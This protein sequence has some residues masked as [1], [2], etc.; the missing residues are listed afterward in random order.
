VT[1][2]RRWQSAPYL[3][4]RSKLV[5][6]LEF[7][8]ANE[9]RF[10]DKVGKF[11]RQSQAGAQYPVD[12]QFELLMNELTQEGA[13]EQARQHGV[14]ARGPADGLDAFM[15]QLE[16]FI[17]QAEEDEKER[18]HITSFDFP[19]K[20]VSQLVGRQGGNINALREKYD[21]EID[22]Q[23]DKGKVHI[24]GPKKNATACQA[25]IM[26]A[27]KGWEDEVNFSLIMEPRF[28][29][30]VIGKGGENLTKLQNKYD[31][32]RIQFPRSGSTPDDQS[33]AD[34]ASQIGG[35]RKSRPAQA[36]NVVTVRGPRARA[37]AVRKELLDLEQF[38][39]DHSQTTSVSVA[40]SQIPSL[41]GKGGREM[42]LLRADTGANIDVPQM[43]NGGSDR[44]EIKLTGS[45]EQINAAKS[46][47]LKKSKTFD[48]IVERRLI[49][50]KKHHKDLIG[51]GGANIRKIV[52]AAGG[53]EN[54]ARAVQFPKGDGPD[55]N[56]VVVRGP[57]EVVDKIC[58]ALEAL[59]TTKDNEITEVVDVPAERHFQLIGTGGDIRKRLETEFGVSINVPRRGSGETGVKITGPASEVSKAISH[60][61]NVTKPKPEARVDIPKSLHHTVS[62]N[63]RLF[64]NLRNQGIIVVHD[65]VRAPP[66]P[67][68]GASTPRTNGNA[69]L[70]TDDPADSFSW[71]MITT[72]P[73]AGDEDM[74][75]WIL[76]GQSEENVAAARKKVEEALEKASKPSTT[77]YLILS[78]PKLHR[79]V[80]GKG[81]SKVGEIRDKTG[82]I[83]QIPQNKP[84]N[85]SEAITIIGD[86]EA[87]EE[88]KE[89]I[90]EAVEEGQNRS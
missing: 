34:D 10:H 2:F 20:Y 6:T 36:A 83:I 86:R 71:S 63:G 60:I 74:I 47:L 11:G 78:D 48:D 79:H 24:K 1:A 31:G 23:K 42:E 29:R 67:E 44:V 70:I 14:R 85:A 13:A 16:A 12:L 65:G 82:C 30:M 61:S 4:P 27:L 28:H 35:S 18:G 59:A 43:D 90:L 19:E 77:G 56:E 38:Y 49:I 22:T 75:P 58:A 69:P 8:R 55:S 62:N 68:S 39:K 3:F 53:P 37:E 66:K 87:C 64:A 21:V 76:R 73:L 54:N 80:V 9:H 32:V 72:G 52:T 40:R 15:K 17:K 5:V 81:G 7:I 41:M 51:A 89:M 46:E 50:D 57:K 26:K 33:V 45:K 25:E 88:A 84:G